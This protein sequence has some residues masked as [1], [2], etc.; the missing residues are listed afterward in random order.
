MVRGVWVP[1]WMFFEGGNG[2]AAQH[3]VSAFTLQAM[4][5]GEP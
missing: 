5:H 2:G 1:R 3:H 4:N